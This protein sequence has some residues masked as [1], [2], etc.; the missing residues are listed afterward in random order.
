MLREGG[1]FV[2]QDHRDHSSPND[3]WQGT[4]RIQ[5][6]SSVA[7]LKVKHAAIPSVLA[8]VNSESR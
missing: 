8:N 6:T 7:G 4:S 2:S 5:S 1:G 3:T